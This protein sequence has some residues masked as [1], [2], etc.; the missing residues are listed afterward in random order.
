MAA[1]TTIQLGYGQRLNAGEVGN[2]P[3]R[4]KI[5]SLAIGELA[6]S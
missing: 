1:G 5:D 2:L 6:R 3:H 4:L